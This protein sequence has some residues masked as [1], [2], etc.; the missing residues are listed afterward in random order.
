MCLTFGLG[1]C[2]MY[3]ESKLSSTQCI[4]CSGTSELNSALLLTK[5]PRWGAGT[6]SL[7]HPL[8]RGYERLNTSSD[9]I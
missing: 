5:D 7:Q 4:S 1:I 9:S 2:G 8:S 3:P 6:P